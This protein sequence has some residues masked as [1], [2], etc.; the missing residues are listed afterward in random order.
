MN[1]I[2]FLDNL[3]EPSLKEIL[4][5][6]AE[7]SLFNP[8]TEEVIRNLS[9]PIPTEYDCFKLL[10]EGQNLEIKQVVERLIRLL[11]QATYLEL[12]RP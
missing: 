10:L 4:V 7:T 5:P 11:D 3:L 2:E 12:L 6:I 1:A 8:V 9:V